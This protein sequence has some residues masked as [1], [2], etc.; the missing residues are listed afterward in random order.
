MSWRCRFSLLSCHCH[1]PP[2][3]LFVVLC[4]RATSASSTRPVTWHMSLGYTHCLTNERVSQ[5]RYRGGPG[6]AGREDND[7]ED[8]EMRKNCSVRCSTSM[9]SLFSPL[10]L[11]LLFVVSRSL[12]LVSHFLF[13]AWFCFFNFRFAHFDSLFLLVSVFFPQ[14]SRFS[15]NLTF[16]VRFGMAI[17]T[18]LFFTT[19]TTDYL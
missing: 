1:P 13:C 7:I 4:Y 11:S 10:G 6:Y 19:H 14:S 17:V 16:R 5:R 3:W 9:V 18:W 12:F 8:G 2:S 15:F